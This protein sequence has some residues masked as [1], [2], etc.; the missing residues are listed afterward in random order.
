MDATSNHNVCYNECRRADG[1]R[2]ELTYPGHAKT[3]AYCN[4]A[5]KHWCTNYNPLS[6]CESTCY[7]FSGL[8]LC[9]GNDNYELISDCFYS[10]SLNGQIKGAECIS[11]CKTFNNENYQPTFNNIEP[12]TQIINP[13]PIDDIPIDTNP[14]THTMVASTPS[15]LTNKLLTRVPK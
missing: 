12:P 11:E 2:Y 10:E 5:M 14:L 8:D 1:S 7:D 3:G 15:S 4:V 13:E 6:Y 9:Y